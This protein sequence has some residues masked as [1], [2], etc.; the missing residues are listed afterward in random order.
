MILPFLLLYA[1]STLAQEKGWKFSVSADP[2]LTWLS[3]SEDVKSEGVLF[4]F[5]FT[6]QA[7]NYFKERYAY[8]VGIS[9]MNFGGKIKNITSE[10]LQFKSGGELLPG[11]TA[12]NR[13]QYLT[14]PVGLKFRTPDYGMMAYYFQAG[15]LPGVR[16]GGNISLPDGTNHGISKDSNVMTC[17]T[18]LGL[19]CMYSTGDNTYVQGGV[20]F[21][22][23]FVDAMSANNI[24]A[25]PIGIGLHLSFLF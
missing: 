19:G 2:E 5:D 1:A 15:L 9:F 4:G 16:I 3:A 7:E 22:Y 14:F 12:K 11:F 13:L 8:Y 10:N 25:L 23:F 20:S 17:G 18:Q 6:V 24:R 21:K